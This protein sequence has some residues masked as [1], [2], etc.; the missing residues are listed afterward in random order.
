VYVGSSLNAELPMTI[1]ENKMQDNFSLK[2]VTIQ[3]VGES[4]ILSLVGSH[5]SQLPNLKEDLLNKL[6]SNGSHFVF[7]QITNLSISLTVTDLD[8]PSALKLGHA[9]LKTFQ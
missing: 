9:V 8:A 4:L 6:N 7:R 2:A 5:L 3:R 1:I